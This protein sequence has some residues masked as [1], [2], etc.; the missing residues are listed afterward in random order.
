VPKFPFF[1]RPLSWA[2]QSFGYYWSNDRSSLRTVVRVNILTV[3]S[4]LKVAL[5]TNKIFGEYYPVYDQD[6][7]KP[8]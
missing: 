3:S 5:Q 4:E 7:T 8:Q 1:E 6:F 2:K